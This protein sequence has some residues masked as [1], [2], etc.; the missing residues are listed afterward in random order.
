MTM[1][2]AREHRSWMLACLERDT[3]ELH[4]DADRDLFGALDQS[5]LAGYRRFLATIYHFEYAVEAKLVYVTDLQLRF[6]ASRLRSGL[7]GEDLLALGMDAHARDILSRPLDLPAMADAAVALGWIYVLQRNTLHHAE[8]HRR[9][10]PT[11][12]HASRYFAAYGASVHQRWT[13]LGAQLDY[14]AC[15]PEIA[16]RIVD[17]ARDAFARQHR[18]YREATTASSVEVAFGPSR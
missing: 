8:L 17:V 1:A 3:R 15:S 14:V 12:P 6:V 18:W 10:A 4:G 9:L 7:L 13:E 5:T 11:F 16:R 2:V